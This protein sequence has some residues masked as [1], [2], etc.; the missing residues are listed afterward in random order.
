M[1]PGQSLSRVV[2]QIS[3]KRYSMLRNYKGESICDNFMVHPEPMG[4]WKAAC[5]TMLQEMGFSSSKSL[6]CWKEVICTGL[7]QR[8]FL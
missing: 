2:M 5:F 6:S 3:C 8:A 1:G 4:S 7:V